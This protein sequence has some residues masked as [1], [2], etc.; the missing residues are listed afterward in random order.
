ME[1]AP[2][3]A[4]VEDCVSKLNSYGSLANAGGEKVFWIF[5]E[6][7]ATDSTVWTQPWVL[8]L[9]KYVEIQILPFDNVLP[10]A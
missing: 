3:L 5:G 7:I 10:L 8:R 6:L 9:V 2:A 1:P 4:N